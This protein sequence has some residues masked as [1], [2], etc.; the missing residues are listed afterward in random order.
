MTT[1]QIRRWSSAWLLALGLACGES[2]GDDEASDESSVCEPGST[3]DCACTDGSMATQTCNAEGSGY[4]ACACENAETGDDQSTD[5]TD[6]TSESTDT[7]DATDN[8]TDSTETTDTTEGP[9]GEAPVS[10]IFHP[11]DGETRPVDVPIPWIGV[12]TDAEDG[13]LTGVALVWS[14]DQD[15]QFGTGEMFDA[16]LTTVGVHVIS[17][18]A[19]DSDGQQSVATIELM[20]E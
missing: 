6:D 13:D 2:G 14:S 16:P 4:D 12:A 18:T 20:I 9:I 15:G 8:T 17:L 5:A 11:G 19:T 1:E 7:T 3:T 10:E